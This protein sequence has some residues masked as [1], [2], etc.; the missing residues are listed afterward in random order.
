MKVFF[1]LISTLITF[2]AVAWFGHM[3]YL[4]INSPTHMNIISTTVCGG[5]SLYFV[6]RD[7]VEWVKTNSG[8]I[9]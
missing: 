6:V 3:I 5:I 9:L 4:T 8:K 2:G 7:A 1:E